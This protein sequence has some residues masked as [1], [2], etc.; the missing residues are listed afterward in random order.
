MRWFEKYPAEAKWLENYSGTFPFYL[1]LRDQLSLNGLLS[2][3]QTESITKAIARDAERA[4][5]LP[6]P[7]VAPTTEAGEIL[8]IKAWLARE[9]AKELGLEVAFR[10]IEIVE[11]HRETA[12]AIQ[13][14]FK[15]VSRIANRC[16]ICGLELD[17]EVSRA[18]GIGPTCAK[19]LGFKRATLADARN[20][21]AK[22]EEIANSIG[23]KGPRWLPKSQVVERYTLAEQKEMA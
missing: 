6:V 22:V 17:T 14:T 5:R 23:V 10:N 18:C 9:V 7:S 19:R 20:I 12:K 16:H 15:Y 3:R 4:A 11:L 21:L 1:S 2:V 8:G 13:C